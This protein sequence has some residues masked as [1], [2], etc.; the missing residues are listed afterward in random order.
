VNEQ[1]RAAHDDG[2]A[3]VWAAGG[4]AVLMGALLIAMHLAS[5]V[6]ARHQAEAA[7]DLAA[8]AAAGI[9]VHGTD[10]ACARA[11]E[12]A[13]AMGGT[14][15]GCGLSGWDT[16]VE[17]QVSVP[18]A[19]PGTDPARARARAGPVPEQAGAVPQMPPPMRPA[20]AP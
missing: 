9:A 8:L 11:G 19:L 4:I 14:V 6:S 17:V 15:A 5:A 10:A 16:L 12:I 3:T 2:A 7:A 20:P 18:L 1:G 13:G